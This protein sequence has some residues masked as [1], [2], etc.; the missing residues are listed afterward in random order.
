LPSSVM[1]TA[2]TGANETRAITLADGTLVWLNSNSTLSFPETFTQQ[3]RR[4]ALVGEGFFEVAKNTALPFHIN[5]NDI[6]IT[7]LGTSF[8]VDAQADS[9]IKIQVSTGKVLVSTQAKDQQLTLEKDQA[10]QWSSTTQ[11]LERIAIN[12]NDYAWQSQILRFDQTPLKDVVNDIARYFNVSISLENKQLE[13]CSF[14]GYFPNPDLI[15][16][17]DALKE[18]YALDWQQTDQH[19]QLYNGSCQ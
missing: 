14:G 11:E 19:Y 1:A 7:V 4:V 2:S 13:N 6:E 8:Q 18:S 15:E 10:A 16:I 9:I 12:S 5:T 17:L 3:E